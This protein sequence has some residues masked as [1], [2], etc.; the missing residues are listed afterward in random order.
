[1]LDLTRAERYLEEAVEPVVEALL[2]AS[3]DGPLPVMIIGATCRDA[4]HLA[5]GHT[6]VLRRTD[7]LDIAL[8]VA[9]W[10]H[11]DALGCLGKATNA[12]S[13][14]RFSVAGVMVDLVPFGEPVESPDSTVVPDW[15]SGEP[16]SVFGFQ[17]VWATAQ[18]LRLPSGHAIRLPTIAGYTVLK[19]K[20]WLD[21]V[22]G[23]DYR[24]PPDLACAMY[25]YQTF[26][27]VVGDQ[28]RLYST[29]EGVAH[30]SAADFHEPDAAVRLLIDDALKL[31]APE[32]RAELR[33]I[34]EERPEDDASPWPTIST[35]PRCHRG[36]GGEMSPAW[37]R[38][39]R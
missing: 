15:R 11:F 20:A 31:L 25:W 3:Y 38:T 27:D 18:E 37:L 24:Q 16:M 12:S 2:A 13:G 4:L 39:F 8:A 19:L 32:R 29:D 35:I 28:G 9:G 1:M 5:A 26:S 34:W 6:A 33:T 10:K 23:G 30:L 22:V 21:R 17:D 14:I 7:D 36:P